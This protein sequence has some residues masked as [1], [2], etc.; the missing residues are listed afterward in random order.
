MLNRFLSFSLRTHLFLIVLLLALPGLA[1]IIDFGLH[2][3]DEAIKAGFYKSK[4]LA[5]SI[6]TEQYNLTGDVEQLATVLAQFPDLKNRN[7]TVV[8][9]ILADI[10]KKSAHYGNIVVTDRT[11]TVWASAL[12]MAEKFSL[13]DKRTFIDA[14]ATRRFS[15]GEYVV[16][17][18]S[19]RPTLGFG[20]PLT[21]AKG[22]FD[23][24]IAIN[25]NFSRFN[26]LVRRTGLPKGSSFAIVD[27]NGIIVN[28]DAA[29]GDWVGKRDP[30]FQRMKEGNDE[31]SFIEQGRHGEKAIVSYRALRLNTPGSPYL[32][33][34]VNIPLEDTLAVARQQQ[35]V[36]MALL[37]IFMLCGFAVIV[38]ITKLCFVDRIKKLQEVSHR[39]G[40]GDFNINASATVQGGELGDL[41]AA[42]DEMAK[43]L[44][45]REV[46][47][48]DIAKER[49]E[50][51][52]LLQKALS[53]IDTLN[54][55][56]PICSFC[57]KIR[58]DN[59][60]WNQ[61]EAYISSH[62]Q[63]LFSHCICPEC[64]KKIMGE[65]LK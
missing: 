44:E 23:G 31:D 2:Q 7:V 47:L 33:V 9:S 52:E 45:A 1:I 14:R 6:A 56:L 27:H 35:F 51:I 17:K 18:I 24:V 12:P 59:G 43:E 61:L 30:L 64:S 37:S 29:G 21:D 28:E 34:R 54:G 13:A 20:Y 65:E 8:S 48:K 3:R 41:A 57:K 60:Y 62:S 50:V 10:H 25:I 15:P 39:I 4:R 55:M 46:A 53:D 5:D 22:Q 26:D 40:S 16:G 19:A 36:Y 38:L 63:A 58:D 11:G 42:F 32:Y 49:E